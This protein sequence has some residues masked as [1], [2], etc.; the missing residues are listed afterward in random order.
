MA[1][2]KNFLDASA[3][4]CRTIRITLMLANGL[5]RSNKQC[6][7]PQKH[8]LLPASTTCH[9]SQD[10]LRTDFTAEISISNLVHHLSPNCATLSF[11]FNKRCTNSWWSK[12]R[13]FKYKRAPDF[14]SIHRGFSFFYRLSSSG[15]IVYTR[16]K[17]KFSAKI[18]SLVRK[19][20]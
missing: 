14:F 8:I 12:S 4:R 13:G 20:K 11:P 2:D 15:S 7:S 19:T 9:P 3:V 16:L 10:F 18:S 17:T 6:L 1:A 5:L